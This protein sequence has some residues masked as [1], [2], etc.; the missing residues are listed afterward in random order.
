MPPALA[1]RCIRA[2]SRVG[3]VVLD[4]FAGAGTTGMVARRLQRRFVGIELNPTFAEMARHRIDDDAPLL[5]R[6]AL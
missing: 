6:M 3:D 5:N 1:D 4:P 2:G